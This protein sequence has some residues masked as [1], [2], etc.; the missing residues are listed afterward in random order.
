MSCSFDT[1]LDGGVETLF[2]AA[3]GLQAPWSVNEVDLNTAKQRI[4]FT[5]T[6]G[7]HKLA[8]PHCGAPEQGIH[9]RL[10]KQ[11]RHLD[12][13]QFEAW[14]HAKV[15]RVK[16]NSCAKTTQLDRPL[17][18]S[19]PC[20]TSSPSPTCAW[21]SL[22]TCQPTP[23]LRLPRLICAL[24]GTCAEVKFHSKRH[25]ARRRRG[26]I[27]YHQATSS[28]VE[29]HGAGSILGYSSSLPLTLQS[30]RLHEARSFAI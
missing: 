17:A 13:F 28:S 11:W 15:P 23:L 18:D 27:I 14:L 6:S 19:G 29:A 3:L 4:D 25:R 16:C 30:S 7:A 22:R 5:V 21:S 24:R 26:S 20:A 12:F 8:C 10:D 1:H 9:D 2:T